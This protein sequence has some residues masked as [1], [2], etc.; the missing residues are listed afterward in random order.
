MIKTL[1]NNNLTNIG[2]VM[3]NR[4]HLP[5]ELTEKASRLVESTSFSFKDDLTKCL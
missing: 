1:K 4:K 2:I 3:A 5:V